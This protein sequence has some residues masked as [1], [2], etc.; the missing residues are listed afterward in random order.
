MAKHREGNRTKNRSGN[1]DAPEKKR[2]C[3]GQFG[4]PHG[5]K[6]HL[7]LTSFC[8]EPEAIFDYDLTD[9]G[10]LKHYDLQPLGSTKNQYIVRLDEVDSPE[11]AATLTNLKLYTDRA[12]LPDTDEDEYYHV[13]L[14]G[15]AVRQNGVK[16]GTVVAV[17]NFGAGDILEIEGPTGATDMISFET[18]VDEVNLEERYL[19]L[20]DVDAVEVRDA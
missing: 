10:G 14:I 19:T 2:V 5:V 18:Q 15:V 13:D 6:G 11:E 8:E 17:H 16:S 4:A 1:R 9:H 3:L 20:A 7:R 12:N